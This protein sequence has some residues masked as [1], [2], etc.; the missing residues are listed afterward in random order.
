MTPPPRHDLLRR[1]LLVAAEVVVAAFLLLDDLARPIYQPLIR[2]VG[3]WRVMDRLDQAVTRQSPLAVLVILA[4]PLVIAEP[5]KLLGVVLIAAGHAVTGLVL[6]AFAYLASF[7][8]IERIYRA[9]KPKLMTMP[10]VA[11]AIDLLEGLHASVLAWLRAT[12]LYALIE[13]LRGAAK[14]LRERIR[15]WFHRSTARR[16]K[17]A[18]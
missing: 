9:G 11:W 4:V 8:L 7:L 5:L 18:E 16:S 6:L 3:T 17:E 12:A 13:R 14:R 15:A 10:W 1:S 2:L